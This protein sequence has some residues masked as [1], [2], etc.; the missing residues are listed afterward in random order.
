MFRNQKDLRID[1]EFQSLI[2][3]L[4]EAEY[5]QLEENIVSLGHLLSPIIECDGVILDGH[6]RYKIL[7]EHPEIPLRTET[8]I[9]DD[10][11]EMLEWICSNQLGRRNLTPEQKR[12]LTGKKY[13][14]QK[15][16]EKFRGNQYTLTRESGSDTLYQN[17][18]RSTRKKL[19]E[20]LGVS[21][22][23]VQ[24]ADAYTRGL[25]HLETIYPGIKDK[26]LS[27][28]LKIPAGTISTYARKASVT[29]HIMANAQVN[30]LYNELM[31]G[32]AVDGNERAEKNGEA[33]STHLPEQYQ[34]FEW[35]IFQIL[36]DLD[37]YFERTPELLS[38]SDYY[39]KVVTIMGRL[40]EYICAVRSGT[41]A[42]EIIM[43]WY[44]EGDNLPSMPRQKQG[45]VI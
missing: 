3:P 30:R 43:S 37:K 42:N 36:Q 45:G 13:E 9:F 29:E 39:Q 26:V 24:K 5:S 35:K 22:A 44:R 12:Y 6:N 41:Q 33:A 31:S 28:E 19:A 16:A 1:E 25:E 20:E 10:R 40:E 23:Y 21:E 11:T 32:S 18:G 27:G 38:D 34:K 15:S 8:L 4:T 14:A 2:P 17:H 7:Q